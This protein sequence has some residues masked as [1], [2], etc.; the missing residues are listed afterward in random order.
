M[1]GALL[2]SLALLA[3]I[4][5]AD[6]ASVSRSY[7]YF[8]VGGTTPQEL[9]RQLNDHGPRL[10]STGKRHPGAVEMQMVSHLTYTGSARSCH[11]S[12]AEVVVQARFSLPRWTGRAKADGDTRLLWE[13]L[14]ADIKR[15]EE[16]HVAIARRFAERLE[17][18]LLG[19]APRRDC[20]EARRRASR[21]TQ[22]LDA[23]HDAAQK[24]YDRGEQAGFESRIMR[25]MEKRAR[26]GR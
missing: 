10:R 17:R 24:Q 2:A 11:V 4:T 9:F 21:I 5:S 6:A 26:G 18:R 3:A 8:S 7:A 13:V 14:S 16:G 12:K 1:K 25:L 23:E 20:E 22:T 15:H 19:M